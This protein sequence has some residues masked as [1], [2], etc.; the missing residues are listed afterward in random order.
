MRDSR[1]SEQRN[2]RITRRRV[3]GLLVSGAGMA[4]LAACGSVAAPTASTT[5]VSPTTAPTAAAAVGGVVV[6]D[7]QAT[8][9]PKSGGTLRM[10]IVGDLP[11]LDGNDFGAA[12][13]VSYPMFNNLGQ[14]DAQLNLSPELAESFDLSSDSRMLKL[15]LRKGVQFHT[16]REM[17]SDDVKWEIERSNDPKVSAGVLRAFRILLTSVETPD[18]YTVILKSDQPWPAIADY[19]HV[20]NILDQQTMATPD[21]KLNPVGTGPFKFQEY[22]QGDHLSLVK[23]PNY[24]KKGL[25]YLDGIRFQIF[26]D[27][28]SMLVALEAG[29]L[30]AVDTPPIR[31]TARYQTDPNWQVVF[32]NIAGDSYVITFNTKQP[33]T[34]NK[35]LRQAMSYALDRKRIADSVLQNVGAPKNIPYYPS[36]PAYDQAADQ[37]YGF[38]LDKAKALLASAGLSNVE[39][40]FNINSTSDATEWS[41]ISQIYQADLATIGIK[42]N[43]RPFDNPTLGQ[44]LATVSYN[45]IASGTSTV[46]HLH[47]GVL[48]A[49]PTFGYTSNRSGFKPDEFKAIDSAILTE[50]DPAK[51]Q[52]AYAAWRNYF[53][54]QQWAM[55]VTS[56]RPRVATTSRVHGIGYTRAEKLYYDETWLA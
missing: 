26:K 4:L 8:G 48:S 30:D 36:S 20:M 34:D 27:P 28:Q 22:V 2:L 33:P 49:S 18:K 17:T 21:G 6:P 10:G 12:F 45:G 3:L 23:N 9:Q 16:G 51:Q 31:D 46:G 44:M 25:P 15:N 37:F 1:I 38:D 42:I 52:Q 55:V 39:M 56:K 50:V 29:T 35:L 41:S 43:I 40:D 11:S 7:P 24:W 32:N 14:E 5:P 53:L 13:D 19:I 47:A 54:D